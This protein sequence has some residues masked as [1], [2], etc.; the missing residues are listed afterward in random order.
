MAENNPSIASDVA[1]L[2]E[3]GRATHQQVAQMESRMA[4]GFAEFGSRFDLLTKLMLDVTRMGERQEAHSSG[5]ERAHAE[6]QDIKQDTAAWRTAHTRENEQTERRLAQWAGVAIGISLCAGALLGFV[7]WFA[8][9][10]SQRVD[11]TTD[12]VRELQLHE[13]RGTRPAN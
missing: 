13:A 7:V 2:K 12:A 10:L 11:K 1:V 9:G 3:Q 6:I 4:A 5:L 8:A